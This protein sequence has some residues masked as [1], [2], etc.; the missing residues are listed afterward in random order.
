LIAEEL[1]RRDIQRLKKRLEREGGGRREEG[2][3]GEVKNL[4]PILILLF[5]LTFYLFL[6]VFRYKI[7][8]ELQDISQEDPSGKSG[9]A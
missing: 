9:C 8:K 3:E 6:S 4:A 2:G 7:M 1:R 5:Y